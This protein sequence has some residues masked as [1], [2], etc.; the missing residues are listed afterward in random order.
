MDAYESTPLPPR[1]K[2]LRGQRFGRLVVVAFAEMATF[3]SGKRYAKWQ[4]LCDCRNTTIVN[5]K[6]LIKRATRSCGCLLRETTS[7]TKKTH[8]MSKSKLYRRWSSMITRCENKS[9]E[10]YKDYGN[11]GI[12]VC[13]QWRNS[14]EIFLRDVR[15]PP[16]PKHQIDRID[17]NGDYEPGNVHWVTI[18]EQ[19]NNKRSTI[20]LT[21][22]RQTLPLSTWSKLVNIKRK[23]LRARIKAGWPVYMVLTEPVINKKRFY[24]LPST[25]KGTP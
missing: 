5:Q 16:T 15:M 23:T 8:G 10:K 21:H 3:P 9:V 2:D 12:K 24:R 11:R 22:D 20:M 17:N 6:S 18:E 1:L 19:A 4:C 7:L 25:T 14:F 13:E